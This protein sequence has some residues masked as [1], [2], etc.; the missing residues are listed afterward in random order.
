MYYKLQSIFLFNL[1]SHVQ[2]HS[3]HNFD[4]CLVNGPE[5]KECFIC[6]Y[7]LFSPVWGLSLLRIS[8]RSPPVSGSEFDIFFRSVRWWKERY[9]HKL[10]IKTFFSKF[11]NKHTTT[12]MDWTYKR[13]K[14]CCFFFCFA[15]FWA[16]LNYLLWFHFVSHNLLFSESL[17]VGV[18]QSVLHL[19]RPLS[20]LCHNFSRF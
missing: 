3:W 7:L 6:I 19:L 14:K 11:A 18:E 2:K 4:S 12:N 20:L 15:A 9:N 10:K 8:G 17:W 5:S 16:A 1:R 13:K